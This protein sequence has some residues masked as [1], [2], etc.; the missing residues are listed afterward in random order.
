MTKSVKAN[1]IVADPF[2]V[3]NLSAL[4]ALRDSSPPRMSE[5]AQA[6]P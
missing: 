2:D 3:K 1:E 4:R 6:R 5:I